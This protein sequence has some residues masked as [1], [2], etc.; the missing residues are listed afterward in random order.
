MKIVVL[1]AGAMGSIYAALMADAGNEVWIIDPWQQHTDA[2][3]NQGLRVEGASGDRTVRT[4]KVAASIEEIVTADL[5]II[6]TKAAAVGEAAKTLLPVLSAD[7]IVLTIQNG[8]GSG[9]R[10]AAH[11]PVGQVLLGVAE[12]FGASVK[13][14]GHVQHTAMKMIR[15]GSI[16]DSGDTRPEMIAGVWRNAGFNA[17][18]YTD[19]EQL[20][21]EKF[22]CNV[23][24]SAPCTVF[25]KSVAQLLEDPH[26]TK[27]S[28][29]CAVEAWQV[30]VAKKVNLTFTDPIEYVTAFGRKVGNARPSLLLDHMAKRP[31][32]IDAINGMVPVVASEQGLAAPFN[33]VLS[34]I[35]RSREAEWKTGRSRSAI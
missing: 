21:W 11:L 6:A 32:E 17:E 29:T 30:A 31:S 24:Y 4:I 22:I 34:G 27:I 26:A 16:A 7:S 13:K 10:I 23:A 1:G 14:P 28:Q 20:I 8:L 25:D 35:V 5:F 33:E 2:I 15:I 18:A 12:G 19:I 9:E 3:R